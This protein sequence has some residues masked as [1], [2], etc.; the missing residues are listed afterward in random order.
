MTRAE[1][2]AAAK[3]QIT[4]NIGIM[5]GITLLVG[6]ICS[7]GIGAI[8]M[9]GFMLSQVAIYLNMTAGQK[10]SIG[11]MFCRMRSLGKGWW[12]SILIGVFTFLWT[13]LLY[14][15]GIIKAYSYSMAY[16][17]LAENPNMTAREALNI[18]KQITNGHKWEL[19]VL[20]LSFIGWILLS[21]VTFG[22]ALIYVIPYM[23][24]TF[25]NFYNS[26]KG[27]TTVEG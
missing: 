13:L 4:G 20:S 6:I 16:Y 7:T 5:F 2:K 17:V 8:L 27:N 14:I 15:P 24:A 11:D 19:F 3:Q 26:I 25:A 1:M 23:N 21:M 9:P 18:S 10:A 22:I 12:L